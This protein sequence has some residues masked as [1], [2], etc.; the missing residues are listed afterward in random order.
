MPDPARP[1]QLHLVAGASLLPSRRTRQGPDLVLPAVSSVAREPERAVDVRLA[2][3]LPL[4]WDARR[5]SVRTV[6]SIGWATPRGRSPFTGE[7][8]GTAGAGAAATPAPTPAPTPVP[9]PRGVDA[10]WG[11]REPAAAAP[12]RDRSVRAM[13]TTDA[14]IACSG[15]GLRRRGDTVPPPVANVKSDKAV[16][17]VAAS[18]SA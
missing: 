1:A 13:P 18:A 14:G 9:A 2:R 15:E 5:R 4:L 10:P 17:P 7:P 16:A 6:S 12:R 3:R 8:G 11:T